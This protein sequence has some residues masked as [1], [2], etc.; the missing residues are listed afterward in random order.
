MC[1]IAG[2][3]CPPGERHPLRA[4]LGEELDRLASSLS[5]R[6]PDAAG[7]FQ[8]HSAGI[9]HTRLAIIDLSEAGA[10]PMHTPDRDQVI[11]YN[12]EIYNFAELRDELEAQGELFVG[13]SDTEVIL[14]LLAREGEAA[15][16]RFDGM[17]ALGLLDVHSG[18]LLLARDRS[19]QK[20][21]YYAPIEG[22]GWAFA[23]E[24][25][26]L[27][28]V[29]GVDRGIDPEGL[30]HLLTFGLIPAPYTLRTG[31]RQLLPGSFVRLRAGH[32]PRSGRFVELPGPRGPQ[33]SGDVESLSHDLEAV[34]SD[35][36]RAHL[37]ADV[38]VGA[39]LSG[40]VD[41]SVV[42]ALAARHVGRLET[43]CVVHSDPAYDESQ[44]A[45]AVAEAIGSVH[46]EIELSDSP[47]SEDE[48]TQLVDHHG[49]P[50]ADSSS[51]AV[52]RVSREMRRHV[53][54]AL[55]GDGGDEVFAG[56]PRFAQLRMLC[57]LARLPRTGLA[58]GRGLAGQFPGQRPRQVARSLHVAQMPLARRMVAFTNL[59]WPEEQ[60][61][62][63][64]PEFAVADA[65]DTLDRLLAD[66][67]AA[68]EADPV[69]SAHWL[70][71]SLVL[72]DDMLTKV[73]RMSMISALEVRPP[74]LAG[75]VLDFAARLPFEVKHSGLTG[76]LVLRALARRLVPPWVIDRPKKGF[77]IPLEVH[78]GAVLEDASRFALE[79]H[80]SP[81]R[82][83][84]REPALE[85]LG[86]ALSLQGEGRHPEDS[87]MR[88]IH[89]RW[90]LLLLARVLMSQGVEAHS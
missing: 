47:L 74:L 23:S 27:L 80:E 68:L 81:L 46:H 3:L 35:A 86:T 61:E 56:Y 39:L 53:T 12:G 19:G 48:L 41:S 65:G 1:G 33:L 31:I 90:L 72:P 87:P 44:A 4:R 32:S 64:R 63:L 51:L 34:L 62:L 89:R 76:K 49:D 22:G 37:V 75:K 26:P 20:P 24:L 29:P 43:F 57:G 42:S 82:A 70:E 88:R 28:R 38:P 30:S 77:A 15:L 18:E 13:G 54:V 52:M 50:F 21:V 2:I 84:F 7:T 14:R 83:V 71:Q 11:S 36:V 8:S 78:G 66:R 40:G 55:S 25:S 9:A 59:F 10:Q 16:A 17:F 73:D 45:R 69:A 79:S 5:H 58:L 60:H 6:G 85:R 67:G